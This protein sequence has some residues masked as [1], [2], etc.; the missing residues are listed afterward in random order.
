MRKPEEARKRNWLKM[1]LTGHII[2]LRAGEE[3][4][5][6]PEE[7]ELF[8]LINDYGITLLKS[9]DKNSEKLGFSVRPYQCAVCGKRSKKSYQ[10]LSETGIIN[11]CKEHQ[12]E[13]NT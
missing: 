10:I 7:M 12:K 4:V 13:E 3:F 6:T 9:W 1:K 5:V 11:V 2:S 8:N